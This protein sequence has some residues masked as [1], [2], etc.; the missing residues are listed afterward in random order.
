MLLLAEAQWFMVRG[1]VWHLSWWG[2]HFAMLVAFTVCVGALLRQYR[3]T[4][5]LGAIVEG[6]F[7]RRQ[8]RGLRAGD[9]RSLVALCAAVAAKDSET[10][11]HIGR[12]G[13]FSVAIAERLWLPPERLEIISLAGRLHDVGKIGVLNRILRKPGPLTAEEFEEMKL[14]SVR[15]WAIAYRSGAL[16]AVAPIIRAH[17]EKLDGTGYPDRLRGTEISI[18][19]RIVA[20][21]DI[22][23]AL[24]C[25][26][27]YRK[28]MTANDA[29]EIMITESILHLD[30][31]CAQALFEEVGVTTRA[32]RAA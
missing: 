24:T 27:P 10:A 23:D 22:W 14:H 13:D 25:D 1:Q 11:D 6:L 17:H 19:A 15:G 28:A 32:L 3:A 16:A 2:Y 20:V 5:D 30:R 9:S 18:E 29:A 26:R 21:A 4:G 7:L 8:V 31:Q 12:V